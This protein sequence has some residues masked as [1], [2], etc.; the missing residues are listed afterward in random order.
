MT[1]DLEALEEQ[2]K[3]RE[4]DAGKLREQLEQL[5]AAKAEHEETLLRKFSELLNAKKR[6]IRDQQRLLKQATVNTAGTLQFRVLVMAVLMVVGD[7]SV[8]PRPAAPSRKGKRKAEAGDEPEQ[9]AMPESDSSDGEESPAPETPSASADETTDD[10]D[11]A[12]ADAGASAASRGVTAKEQVP[13]GEQPASTTRRPSPPPVRELP[14]ASRARSKLDMH[15]RS[16]ED[17]ATESDDEL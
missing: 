8:P 7:V 11:A 9:A 14:F 10:E 5:I 15:D 16:A 13:E 3:A 4:D 2:A 12:P 1:A 17:S 6:R